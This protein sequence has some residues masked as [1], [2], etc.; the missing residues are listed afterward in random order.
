MVVLLNLCVL[1]IFINSKTV[2]QNRHHNL[3][4]FLSISDV[5]LGL[6]GMIGCLRLLIPAW[7]EAILPCIMSTG[8]TSAGIFMSMFQTFLLSLH[9]FLVSVNSPCNDRLFQ[10]KRKYGIYA[11]GWISS[12]TWIFALVHFTRNRNLA[13]CNVNVVYGDY[14]PV[15]S[16]VFGV[17][18]MALLISTILLYS[19]TLHNVRKRYMKTFAWQAENSKSAGQIKMVNLS[20]DVQNKTTKTANM[21]GNSCETGS[22]TAGN[23]PT[24]GPSTTGN[25][26]GPSTVGNSTN[27]SVSHNRKRKVFESLKVIGII[28]LL[29]VLLTGP[30]V[31]LMFM[32]VFNFEPSYISLPALIGLSFLNSALNPFIYGWRIDPLREEIRSLFRMCRQD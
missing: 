17:L 20:K 2:R 14:F 1:I 18:G 7:S 13:F 21:T 19:F 10:G 30:F 11:I 29:L 15:F 24:A 31:V 3:V 27:D 16:R 8:L 9:R 4:L 25:K 12:L 22:S 26:T 28:L 5:I 23:A 32:T 6:S